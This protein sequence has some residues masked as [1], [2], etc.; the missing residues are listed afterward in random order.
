MVYKI[1]LMSTHGTGKTTLVSDVKGALK[2]KGLNV[3]VI[4]ELS[5]IARERNIPIDQTTTLEAQAWI[6]YRQCSAELEAEIYKYDVAICDRTVLDNYCYLFNA[7]GEDD[8]YLRLVLDFSKK[9]PYDS[10]FYLPIIEELNPLK[11]SGS[12]G[13]AGQRF[14]TNLG[15]IFSKYS[16]DSLI[17]IRPA[18]GLS[19]VAEMNQAREDYLKQRDPDPKF[20]EKI[21]NLLTAFLQKHSIVYTPLSLDYGKWVDII[22]NKTLED[23]EKR[24]SDT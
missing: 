3:R 5:T 11:P 16:T 15:R 2:K 7:V 22:V 13:E 4:D 19:L 9:H 1:G 24:K 20:Q 18:D 10:L 8:F 23:L 12:G 6:L 14:I 21:D 17:E